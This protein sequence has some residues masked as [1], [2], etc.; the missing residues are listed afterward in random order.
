MGDT[1]LLK[2]I[3]LYTPML[4]HRL[5]LFVVPL[6]APLA[7]LL[8]ALFSVRKR[9]L[10]AALLVGT[11]L[12]VAFSAHAQPA[13]PALL[14]E[15]VAKIDQHSQG[16]IGVF[17]QDLD[18]GQSASYQAD[19]RW[20]LASMV[21]VP[22][23]IA[24]LRGVQR[25]SFTLNT[26]LTLRAGD[27]VDGAGLTNRQPVG[28][29]LPISAL[30]EQMIIHSDNTASDMLIDLVGISEVNAVVKSLVPDASWHIT[31]LGDVRQQVYGAL[32][33]TAHQLSGQ[34]LI[35]L[36]RQRVDADRL[37]LLSQLADTPLASFKLPTLD[38]AYN[39]Y[40]ASGRNSGRLDAYGELLAQLA[41][42][43]ALGAVQTDY[44][45]KLMERVATG[46]HRLKAGLPVDTP[47]A[48]KTGT[49][50]RRICDAGLIRLSDNGHQRRVVVVAC[51]RDDAS[52]NRSELALKQVGVALCSSGLLTQGTTHAPF[53]QRS[54]NTDRLPADSQR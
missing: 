44:L 31:T 35:R 25:G 24:V 29:T 38:A 9:G 16:R 10:K 21:K 33:P 27:Y 5:A 26:T 1:Q 15:S 37:Q 36:N 32:V 45:L 49:Q 20:Y 7:A 28:S 13:W 12:W 6:I 40:Y 53:C 30:M 43:K 41:N 47:F 19:Q 39:V 8:V 46:T 51:S 22:V 11:S 34:D 18:S 4:K 14:I 2:V 50:R 23:A 52:L 42:G 54:P 17:V 3:F 48:H